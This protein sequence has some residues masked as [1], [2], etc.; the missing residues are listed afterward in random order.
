[1]NPKNNARD[2]ESRSSRK[3]AAVCHGR[4]PWGV[5]ERFVY[6]K[7]GLPELDTD[8]DPKLLDVERKP[9]LG[10]VGSARARQMRRLPPLVIS[11]I[12]VLVS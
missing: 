2:A 4:K 5:T 3:A 11:R 10:P 7:K 8:M 9:R 1:M 12:F 6:R